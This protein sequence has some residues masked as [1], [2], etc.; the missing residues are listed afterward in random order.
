MRLLVAAL[1]LLSSLAPARAD[2]KRIFVPR[3]HKRLQAAIDAAAA[4][5]TVWVGPGTYYGPFTIKKRIVLF[6]EDGPEKTILDGHDTSRV[7]HIEGV[8]RMS[9]LGFRIQNGKAPGGSGIYC[10]RDTSI[11]IGSCDVRGNAETGIALWKCGAVQ[12]GDGEIT[13]NTGSGLTASESR[14]LLFNMRFRDNRAPT[15]GGIALVGSEL[16]A[17]KDCLFESNRADGGTGGAIFAESSTLRLQ[18][19]TFRENTAA[20]GGGAVAVMDSSDLRIRMVT[21]TKNRSSTGG[22]VLSDHSY[23]DSSGSIYE[24]NRATIAGAAI[25]V[26]G[27]R[28]AGVNPII[29]NTTFYRNGVDAEQGAAIYTDGIAPEISHCIFVIDS[30]GRNKAV[31]QDHGVPKYECNLVQ[32]LDGPPAQASPNTFVGDPAFCD[33]EHGDFHVRDL[34][35]ALLAPCGRIGA[36]GKGCASFKLFPSQ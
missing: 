34:S 19:S 23:F 17:A 31:L 27:R 36:L 14:V 25:Q 9:V 18:A 22:A 33:A 6:G 15:G 26:L 21:F 1:L 10:L 35:P 12:I 16:Y 11:L 4:G 29:V 7:L 20:A 24:R 3:Q 2:A 28:T 32:L 30:T 13:A 5:D 8:S